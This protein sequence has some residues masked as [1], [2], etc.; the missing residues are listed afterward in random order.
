MSTLGIHHL[1][2]AV[3]NLDETAKFFTDCLGWNI[4][5]E[6]PA[7]PAK[8]VSNGHAFLTLWQ[9]DSGATEFNR[10]ENIG[11]HHFAIKVN[12]QH[13]LVDLFEKVS[14]Y[15]DIKV[16]FEPEKL[17]PGPAQHFMVFEPGGIR[18]EFIWIPM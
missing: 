12:S 14:E 18:I 5:K 1:G 3:K 11:L 15:P 16:D 17:G 10:K 4:V 2:L 9:T 13:E 8:F 7:Y 6:V